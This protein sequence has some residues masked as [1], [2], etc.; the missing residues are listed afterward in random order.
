ME[1]MPR[2]PSRGVRLRQPP[3]ADL[4]KLSTD[5]AIPQI[6]HSLV[7]VTDLAQVCTLHHSMSHSQIQTVHSSNRKSKQSEEH[8]TASSRT[9]KKQKLEVQQI[10]VVAQSPRLA[11][12]IHADDQSPSSQFALS[13]S[14]SD[15]PQR[16]TKQ[17][18]NIKPFPSNSQVQL[19]LADGRISVSTSLRFWIL[20]SFMWFSCCGS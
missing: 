2:V 17:I 9:I 11:E 20:H 8:L 6:D 4:I 15:G 19:T 7:S 14:T 16:S 5:P 1:Y 18:P 12:T 10:H 3:T 13:L